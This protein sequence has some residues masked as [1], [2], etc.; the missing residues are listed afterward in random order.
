MSSGDW[1][2]GVIAV[3]ST[4]DTHQRVNIANSGRDIDWYWCLYECDSG[5]YS[6]YLRENSSGE[7]I[8]SRS[9][10]ETG[11]TTPNNPEPNPMA[12]T[13]PDTTTV[14]NPTSGEAPIT[15][16]RPVVIGE[17]MSRVTSFAEQNGY[18]H[19]TTSSPPGQWLKENAAWLN[20]QMDQGNTIID[21]GPSPG[22]AP[23][24]GD[25]PYITSDYYAMEQGLLAGRNYLHWVIMW[26]V[27]D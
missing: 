14:D 7:T 24:E 4:A 2:F 17:D 15:S 12:G 10:S 22:Y 19:F 16:H 13:T 27:V 25:Y 6:G 23:P 11:R 26:G 1:A 21:I 5:E 20:S 18:G 3:L 9:D 8:W